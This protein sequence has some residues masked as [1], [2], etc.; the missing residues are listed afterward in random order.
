[1]KILRLALSH[2]LRTDIPQ[3]ERQYVHAE[4]V[5]QEATGSDWETVL[6]PIWP[7]ERLPALVERWASEEQPD[8]VLLCLAGYWA[9]FASVALRLERNVPIVGGQLAR[10]ARRTAETRMAAESRFTEVVR[11]LATRV[12]GVEYNFDPEEL[13]ALFEGILRRLLQDERLTIAVRGPGLTPQK[14]SR[15]LQRERAGRYQTWEGG[16][17]AVCERL[18]V[19]YLQADP[20]LEDLRSGVR[21]PGDPAH[22]TLDGTRVHGRQ[23]GELMA[24]AWQSAHPPVAN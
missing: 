12:A 22:Y 13:V 7:T 20:L 14:T 18:H 15:R 9:T 6:K 24:R 5:L 3:E 11:D 23:E 8:L 4:R 10:L 2:D 16:I 21:L 17:R 19:V 1:V